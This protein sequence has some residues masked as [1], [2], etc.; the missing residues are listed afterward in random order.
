MNLIESLS[1]ILT[2]RQFYV[3]IDKSL[4]KGMVG[5]DVFLCYKKTMNRADYICYKPEL[6]DRFPTA[7]SP[8]YPLNPVVALFCL[9]L[10]ATMECWR[11]GATN[12]NITKS[13]FVLNVHNAGKVYG[14]S[15][16][17]YEE[18]EESLLT[19]EQVA[20][21]GIVFL[22]NHNL[23]SGQATE[24]ESIYKE[25]R[26]EDHGNQMYLPSVSMAFL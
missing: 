4:N 19:E 3:Q 26:E 21:C 5:S 23:T 16:S 18:Y 7:D 8:S 24:T 14:S 22:T 9:P 2:K 1:Q 12:T 13:T 15:I 17:Y 25:G 6:L 11:T 10:G 20:L